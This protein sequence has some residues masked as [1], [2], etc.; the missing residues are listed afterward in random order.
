M[1]LTLGNCGTVHGRS[2]LML[3]TGVVVV[4][5]Q[6]TGFGVVDFDGQGGV[7]DRDADGLPAVGSAQSH[8]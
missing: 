5:V 4:P 8:L 3:R 2:V 7:G 1:T 6:D